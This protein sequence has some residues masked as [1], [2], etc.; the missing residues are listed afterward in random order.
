MDANS[1]S[2]F[3]EGTQRLTTDAPV[4][5]FEKML[6]ELGCQLS[7]VSPRVAHNGCVEAVWPIE[8]PMPVLQLCEPIPHMGYQCI[9]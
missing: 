5:V 4:I 7:C 2:Q 8:R 3:W 1:P 6:D 9:S